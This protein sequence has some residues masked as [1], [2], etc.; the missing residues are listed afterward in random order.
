MPKEEK[1]DA[2]MDPV[3][4]LKMRVQTSF[5][6]AKGAKFDKGWMAEESQECITEFVKTPARFLF[7]TD[8]ASVRTEVPDK[9]G[10]AKVIFFVK[11]NAD[12]LPK[13]E[14]ELNSCL[15]IMELGGQSIFEH[16]ELISNEVFLPVLSNPGNQAKW[17][18]VAAREIMDRF[19]SFLSST[20]ILCGQ[21]RGETR[22]P[23]PPL[24]MNDPTATKNRIS[25]LEGAIITWTKQIKS[26]LKQDPESQL[27]QGGHP[28]PDVEIA[29]WKN[30]AMNL[31]SIF[32]QLQSQRIRKVLRALDQSKSTY[33]TTFARLC[34]EVFT[35]RMEAND[36][37]K[38]LRTLELWFGQLNDESDFP[39]LQDNFKPMM[40]IILLIWKNSKHYNTPGR[41]VVLMREICNSLINQACKYVSGEQIFARIEADEAGI[42]VEQL[43]TTL[44]V[45]GQFKATY[46]EY[47]NTANA[48]CPANPWRIQNN[49][50]FMRLDSF[51]E[52]CHDILD[53]TQTIVQFGKLANIEVGGTKGKTLTQSV[54]SIHQDFQATVEKFKNVDYDIMDVGAK[55]FDD[56]F[57]GFRVS[58][59]EL[60]RRLGSV[61]SLAYDDCPTVY[62]RFRLFDSFDGL[63]ERPIIQDELEKKYVSLVQSYGSDLKIVQET[64]LAQRDDPPMGLNKPPIT[65]ALNWCRGLKDRISI[66]MK[67]LN[68]LDRTI[69][70]R[71]ESRE[72]YKIYTT[73]EASLDEYTNQKI[74]EWG[75][76]VRA[77][78]QGKLNMPLCTRNEENKHLS[79]NFDPALVR[80]LREV[81]YFLLLG[82]DVPDS[83]QLIYEKVETYR[84]WVGN[85]TLIVDANNEILDQ[86]LPVEEPLVRPYLQQFDE[87]VSA[88]LDS[89]KFNW[90]TKKF[91]VD[92]V[93]EFI[94]GSH[95]K[96]RI[97]KD[98]TGSMK[99]NLDQ[100]ETIM[101]QWSDPA[102][103]FLARGPKPED[104]AEFEALMKKTRSQRYQEIKDGGKLIHTHMKETNKI[105][106][107]SNAA[108]NWRDYVDFNNNIVIDGLAQTI[109]GSLETL[110]DQIDAETIVA[111][112]TQPMLEVQLDLVGNS[113]AAFVPEI[114]AAADGKGLRDRVNGWIGSFFQI[115]TLFK[116]LDN[117]EGNFMRE[118]HTD[119]DV[120]NLLAIIN[121]SLADTEGKCNA[122][123]GTFEE[124]SYLWTTDLATFFSEFEEDAMITLEGGARVKDLAKYEAAI[125]KYTDV[126]EKLNDIKNSQDIDWIRIDVSPIKD[127]MISLSGKWINTFVTALKKFVKC[128]LVDLDAFQKKM[129]EGLQN[130]PKK[131]DIEW[132][133]DDPLVRPGGYMKMTEAQVAELKRVMKN[134][135]E[136]QKS[137]DR[138]NSI[139]QPLVEIVG[140]LKANGVDVD[141]DKVDGV[142]IQDYLENAP[143][144]FDGLVKTTQTQ[145]ESIME[146]QTEEQRTVKT[147]LGEFFNEI[148]TFRGEFR[149]QAPFNFNG[150]C[151][152]AYEIMD[153]YA[154]K[155]EGLAQRA[156]E[157]NELE[158]LF[159]IGQTKYNEITDTRNE[160]YHLKNLYDFKA[161]MQNT[162]NDWKKELWSKVDTD[163]LDTLNKNLNK[164]L[165]TKGNETQIIKGWELYRQIEND[166]KNM[167]IILPLISELHN[168]SMR[169]RHWVQLAKVCGRDKVEPTDPKFTVGDMIE[170]DIHEKP[171]DVSEVVET[172]QKELKI[173]SKLKGIE[174]QW[175]DFELQFVQH[176]DTEMMMMRLTEE[177][178]EALDADQLEL[179]TMIGMGKFVEYFKDRVL[180]WQ[181]T[182]GDVQETTKVWQLV[183]KSWASLESIFLASADIRA[184][185]PEDTKRFEGINSE[186]T[187]L[188]KNAVLTP[189]V[190]ECCT[191]E[192]REEL[193]RSC[194]ERLDI[195]Q[196]SLNDYLDVKRKIFPRFYFVSAVALLDMLANG[197]NPPKIVPYMGDCYDSLTDVTFVVDENG[198]KSKRC[199]NEMIA[200]D[201][202]LIPMVEDFT[203]EGEVEVYLNKLTDIMQRTLKHVMEV[204]MET[205]GSVEW[206]LSEEAARHNWS[207][208]M[209]AQIVCTGSQIVWTEET[210][211]ALEM[212]EGG[213]VDAVKKYLAV[214]LDRLNHLIELVLGSMTKGNRTK[215]ITLITLDV[216]AKEIVE[217]LISE[218]VDTPGHFLWQQQLRFDWQPST[219]DVGVRICDYKTLYFWEWVGNV[220]RLVITPLTDKCYITLTMGLRLFL[221]G[222]PAGP[223]GTGK[224]ETTKD[225]ARALA[226]PCYVYNCSDQMNFQTL[227][228]IF[229]G[230]SQTGAWGCFDEFNRIRIET[231]SVVATQVKTVQDAVVL[232]SNPANRVGDFKNAPAG[233]PPVRVGYFEFFGDTISLIPTTSHYITMNPG[234]AGRTELPE[235]L[236]ALFRSCAM[237]RP[238][239]KPICENM[240]MSEGFKTAGK[241]AVKFVTLYTL[242]SELL[243]KQPH[244]D[245]G[246]RAVKSVLRCAG[247]Y[248]RAEPTLD[249]AQILMRAL[250]DFNTPKIPAHDTPVFLRLIAD[251]FMGLQ[252]PVKSDPDL[253]KRAE[254]VSVKRGMQP[255][256]LFLLKVCN[257]DELLAVRHSVMLLGPAG[258]AKTQIWK[259]LQGT[260]NI[261]PSTF[262]AKKK[263]T[264]VVEV[265]NPKSVYGH[266]LYGYMTLAKDWKD[267]VLSIIMRG[268]SKNFSEQNFYD[269]QTG[270]WVVLD[271]DIDAVWI[272]SMNTVMDDNKVLTLVSNERVPLS[273]AMRMVFEIN[274]L[275][276]ATPATVSRAGILYIN[277]DDIGW[278]PMVKSWAE[279][280]EDPVEQ[281]LM[282]PLFE[283][284]IAGI[285]E[286]T[287]RGYKEVTRC[288]ILNKVCTVIYLMEQILIGMAPDEKT[289]DH[290]DGYFQYCL[291]WAFGGPLLIDKQVDYRAKFNEDFRAL[292]G[293]K[294]P[295]EGSVFD[296]Y[297]DH[298]SGKHVD[299]KTQ[300]PEYVPLEIG[301]KADA[302]PFTAVSVSSADTCRMTHVLDLLSRNHKYAMLV[303]TAGTGKS[304][305]VKE[306]LHSLDKDA[307][308]LMS[309]FIT[310]S[311]FTDSIRLQGEID[312]PI[313]KMAGTMYGPPPG[314]HLIYFIDDLNLP[315]IETYGTQNAIAL[316][317]Q[318]MAHGSCFDRADL[319]MRKEICNVQFLAAM[320]PT[321]GSFSVCERAQRHFATFNCAMPGH[322]DLRTVYTAI[323]AGHLNGFSPK[324]VELCEVIVDATLELHESVQHKFLPSAVKFMYKWNMR[325][326]ANVFQGLTLSKSNL[327]SE[328]ID[329]IRLWR[330]ECQRVFE[331]RLVSTS[332]HAIYE[333]LLAEVVKKH[334]MDFK[335]KMIEEPLGFTKFCDST[336]QEYKRISSDDKL[337]QVMEHKLHEYNESGLAVMDLVLFADAMSH[338]CRI[339]RII[340]NP[341][342]NAMLIG[343]GGSGK[344]SLTKLASFISGY[345]VNQI[346]I[347]GKYGMPEFQEDLKKAYTKAIAKSTPTVFLMT[348]T[349]IVKEE[350]LVCLN[351]MLAS[352]WISDLFARDEIDN[353]LG[354]LRNE[355]KSVGI[356][357]NPEAMFDFLIKRSKSLLKVALAFSPV[358]DTFRKRAVKFPGLIN[359]TIIDKFHPWPRDALEGVAKRFLDEVEVENGEVIIPKLAAHMAE[360]HLSTEIASANYLKSQKRYNYVTPKSFLELI[361]FY[362]SLL[363]DKRKSV[364][365][366]I[367][368]LDVGLS[369]MSKTANDVAELKV[370]LNHTMEKVAE[371]VQA[372]D[373]LIVQMGIQRADAEKQ[374]AAAA[375]EKEKADIESAKAEKIQGEAQVELDKAQPAMD[376]ASE[377]VNCLKKD[378]IQ[379][380][381]G[382]KQ[383]PGAE[384]GNKAMSACLILIEKNYTVK[385]HN[386]LPKCWDTCKKMMADPGKFLDRLVAYR[387]E[388]MTEHEV[389]M[390][391]ER[392]TND[393]DFNYDRIFKSSSALANIANWVI[394]IYKYNRIYVQV[395][396]LMESL[397]SAKA[398]KA[399]ADE[400][401]GNAM[402]IVQAVQVKLAGLQAQ[403]ETAIE[404][405]Q[406]VE[407]E[408]ERCQAKLGLAERL[409]GGLASE[410]ERW[411]ITIL[412]LK[413]DAGTLLGDCMLAAGFVSYVGAFDQPNRDKLWKMQWAPDIKEKG[414][415]M[416]DGEVDPL[417]QLTNSG[418]T[419]QMISESLP[420][421]RVSVEN[422]SVICACKRWPLII[423][424]QMQG[425][426][427]IRNKEA[428][429]N[430]NVFQLSNKRALRNVEQALIN[431]Y[432]ILIENIGE[433]IDATLDPVLARAIYKKGRNYFLKLAGEEVEYDPKFKLYLQ[434]K[435]QNPHYKPEIAAQCTLINFIA[436]ERGLEDQLLAKVV[437]AERPDLEEQSAK[438]QSDATQYKIQLM[439]LEDE[440]LERLANAPEDILSDIPLIEGLEATKATTNEINAQMVIM[441]QTEADIAVARESYRIMATEGAMLYFMLTKLCM[442]DHMYRYSLDA[443]V[444]FFY[445]AISKAPPAKEIGERVLILRE[446]LRLTIFTWCNRGLFERHKIILCAQ[447]CFELQRRGTLGEDNLLNETH[448]SFLMRGPRKTGT[449]NPLSWLPDPGWQSCQALLE[450]EDFAPF[451][452]NLVEAAPRFREWYNHVTP[453]HE[454]L[455]LDWAALDR[456]PFK[457]LLVVRALRPDRVTIGL[458][459]FIR[460]TLPNGPQFTECDGASNSVEILKQS[461]EDSTPTTPIYFILSPGANVVADLESQLSKQEPPYVPGESYHNIA[462][463]EGMD[464]VALNTL[465]TA[466][467]N[468]HW[469]IL[470][471]VHLMPV[472]CRELEKTLDDFAVEGSH[473]RFRLFLTSDPSKGI[474]EGIL[475]RCIKLTNEPPG[476]LKANLKRAFCYFS[477]DQIEEADSKTKCI[478]F[479][480]CVFHSVMMERKLYGPMGYNMMYPFSL[481]DLRDSFRCLNNYIEASGGGKIPW[482]DLK[483]I[484]GEIMYGG[485]I[486]NDFDLL[487][488]NTYLEFY[489]EDNL[490]DVKELYPY[491]EDEK[492]YSFPSPGPTSYEKYLDHIEKGIQ[493]DSPIAFGLHPNAEIDF[494]T[495]ACDKMFHALAELQMGGGGGGGDD[496][497]GGGASPMAIAEAHMNDV[498]DKLADKGFDVEDL[499]RN[500]DDVGPYQNV[501]M[502]EMDW[503]NVL[504]AEIV[505]SLKELALGFAGELTMSDAM[506]NLQDSLFLDRIPPGWAKK[507]WPSQLKFSMWLT[508]FMQ[509]LEQ[510]NEWLN[511]PAEI[512][513]VTWISGMVNP[514]S[515]LTAIAQVA[516]QKNMWELDKLVTFTEVTKMMT[517]DEVGAAARDG[518]YVG[519]GSM[520][521]ARWDVGNNSVEKSKP[522]ELFCVMPIISVKG[523]STEKGGD[524]PHQLVNKKEW[525]KFK[526]YFMCPCYKTEMRGPTIVFSAQ[527]K[528]RS[529]A[530]RWVMGGVAIIFEVS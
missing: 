32:E 338:V 207:L 412:E 363:E 225:L 190:I 57:Y 384:N 107:C 505:R 161:M 103:T 510:L 128:E 341:S 451:C 131:D 512:P 290:L 154:A 56:D 306:Y 84:K 428:A 254:H 60:E 24:D 49:A 454:K 389:D 158:D 210:E 424:P 483:Y 114:E 21:V 511:N 292:Y 213:D 10:K 104:P 232:Y 269:Y 91:E 251:L 187:E 453:E 66:P 71:E 485:H 316:L 376:A 425:I 457:K 259:T 48:E 437:G 125:K 39:K 377:A 441:K 375:I 183:S 379:E 322:E 473:T 474:P 528:T 172:A 215:I 164:L 130:P 265:V 169:D 150:T 108:A 165:R 129:T 339:S 195:C 409:V 95:E 157:A 294:Y 381:K 337:K 93:T 430:L 113:K 163:Y 312:L 87:I 133:D 397:A 17:G 524:F 115:S 200:K 118:M 336:T 365:R 519:G 450:V 59:K 18:E 249:E 464:Q 127:A 301:G 421:D 461:I 291:V 123:K 205:S 415:P 366:L 267:G 144:N 326:L 264:H 356:P 281:K 36:N 393:P 3:E 491:V 241:L 258:C 6:K 455:P 30:K 16:L 488:A 402:A 400:A 245:W 318:L 354:A 331:D 43:K 298:T 444:S 47:R 102:K 347:T 275:R 176:K 433:D 278:G 293:Q 449:A 38:Y 401:L 507:A 209:P 229:R 124:Y 287:R 286:M 470:N 516:A 514:Q 333:G 185:L 398:A 304:L 329:M 522:K 90:D 199:V 105:L 41:L 515:F 88:A 226:L 448:L 156:K 442:I 1:K 223:A 282:P 69:L 218:K 314:K 177:I 202:E 22:L 262:E 302:T 233:T 257:F 407:A 348:D 76:D 295:A 458:A 368:R 188:M 53:L 244:Y 508:N 414:I 112:G 357:D 495:T 246:L 224:T 37:M 62:G 97:V 477:K 186:F 494:R 242:S 307:D 297:Y 179:Q 193:L 98:I 489:M 395:A 335:D 469:V 83:A 311:Y 280:R 276:N 396:P 403:Y 501:F 81:K 520:M 54:Q 234:Y 296:Y 343:V 119:Y 308:K 13:G 216:H 274:S 369:T 456:T 358:G 34:R 191:F 219:Q 52:R 285:Q 518:A 315:Y 525:T 240:L 136:V 526:G 40:H 151:E 175:A 445:K 174:A 189:K 227:A 391:T 319:G 467:R 303:G 250:R 320:D 422:G 214:Q 68:E 351:A 482:E 288:Q 63:L 429:N 139:F 492:G 116:R 423:D 9:V 167:S 7:V 260:Y 75:G 271:G 222:A 247:G 204:G 5:P 42:A 283:K 481:G 383:C 394:N 487:L 446:S 126:R 77:S 160:L 419:A 50:L 416:S 509:R 182:L 523:V 29:F 436:T 299:W 323:F 140:L 101:E 478:L 413:R 399:A 147:T 465:E 497:E 166:I 502:Q 410:N 51:L 447:L 529:P 142:I 12:P 506:E 45:C 33:C 44:R 67:K 256:D 212:M 23:M 321:C 463:G 78:S 439:Q 255:T 55:K 92:A 120:G 106:K 328:P 266:E 94:E 472:W 230:L 386:D 530:A 198:N 236:K 141:D 374:N 153:K 58:I 405:K 362:K 70:D 173:E 152:E 203:M 31:N 237:I 180:K 253:R 460:K 387:G 238:D 109:V 206:G 479:G 475:A 350:F 432:S 194:K 208:K 273:A 346:M 418:H 239:L 86:L 517:S 420:D 359:C 74:E 317:T 64:F 162:H 408:A 178:I 325:E 431:G 373:E 132:R 313:E 96:I 171:D 344:Q 14:V 480:L 220:Q 134:I 385:L 211:G 65:G 466:H 35:A 100:V 305:L 411:G 284:Y 159:E 268:M 490:L 367:D 310:M 145:K 8:A 82:L 332:E 527:V 438:L 427:W 231:L 484:F 334:F 263:N 417:A 370:D 89:E 170:F 404:A 46:F 353:L 117:P 309:N 390:L 80:L 4:F 217:R 499:A 345:E 324:L 355:A 498:M 361:A 79:V 342:G 15:I 28:T 392:V 252:V 459:D 443:Y 146:M 201:G 138:I 364:Q 122:L 243:S 135:R 521:G 61:V 99:K 143:G 121:D 426:K 25:L 196:K 440:L 2:G 11:T 380:L 19:Y 434:T 378:A 72:I 500:L 349:Q 85:L 289:E 471:N 184:S 235:N 486:V 270:K 73:I 360:E 327:Y 111:N 20:T 155:L 504:I 406:K 248:K 330:H 388:D 493:Q 181:K 110:L 272:E 435:L 197:T 148:R 279:A 137:V 476:G 503:M 168:P 192:G 462:M 340:T 149:K 513:K 26:V 261:D 371:Q 277:E 468:G 221:G 27:K 300:V 372:T 228:D 496:D 452:D 352:G 382:F